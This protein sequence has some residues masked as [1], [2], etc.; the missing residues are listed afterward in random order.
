MSSALRISIKIKNSKERTSKLY[1]VLCG[2]GETV[3]SMQLKNRFT[4]ELNS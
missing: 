3:G 4:P 1:Y 2:E